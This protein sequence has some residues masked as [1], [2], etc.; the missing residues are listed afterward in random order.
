MGDLAEYGT[1]QRAMLGIVIQDVNADFAERHNTKEHSGV[2]ISSV[3][4]GSAA[5][6]AGLREGDIIIKIDDKKVENVASLQE[7]VARKHP[8]DHI[9]ITYRRNGVEKTTATKLK[10]VMGDM[11]VVRKESTAEIDGAIFAELN[12]ELKQRL[13]L[14]GGVQLKTLR[15]AKWKDS[16]IKEGFIITYIDKN[17][18]YDLEDLAVAI[19]GKNGRYFLEGLYPNGQE[20]YFRINDN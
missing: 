1:V 2:Y 7:L 4:D 20:D 9:D 5:Q 16:G 11:S 3:N 18:V 19:S 15:S 6:D 8:G 13:N 17:P 14:Q 10:N 12:D